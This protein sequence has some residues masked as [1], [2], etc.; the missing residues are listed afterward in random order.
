MNIA[1][2][3]PTTSIAA[4]VAFN[5][6]LAIRPFYCRVA[7]YQL[8]RTHP[9]SSNWSTTNA[10]QKTTPHLSPLN[11]S[12]G[13]YTAVGGGLASLPPH[14]DENEASTVR[15]AHVNFGHLDVNQA[16]AGARWQHSAQKWAEV[17][18]DD[19]RGWYGTARGA[20]WT[21]EGW[22]WT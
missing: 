8:R 15:L 1:S 6:R 20:R 19:C 12:M 9:I 5:C 10:K 4:G 3:S 16:L 22:R 21:W 2:S 7:R 13:L 17:F 14:N 11:N 18:V